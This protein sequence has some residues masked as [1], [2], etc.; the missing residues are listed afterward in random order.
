M[1]IPNTHKKNFIPAFLHSYSAV[2]AICAIWPFKAKLENQAGEMA[3]PVRARP[4][5]YLKLHI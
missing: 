3:I 5:S 4:L 1:T 2:M